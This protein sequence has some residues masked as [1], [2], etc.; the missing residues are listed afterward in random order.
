MGI[1][2]RFGRL[3]GFH[4]LNKNN[5]SVR[6]L[7]TE[8]QG[9]FGLFSPH[10][11]FFLPSVFVG[12]SQNRL[13]QTLCLYMYRCSR[14]VSVILFPNTFCHLQPNKW[15]IELKTTS[16]LMPHHWRNFCRRSSC[17]KCNS[18][19]PHKLS[20]LTEGWAVTYF[21]FFLTGLKALLFEWSAAWESA[22]LR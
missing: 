14:Q 12:H 1:G 7:G 6:I 5:Y 4:V 15:H 21:A 20:F 10:P 16:V 9:L 18:H 3:Q 13:I 2:K 22:Y 8:V 19:I 11:L 17:S